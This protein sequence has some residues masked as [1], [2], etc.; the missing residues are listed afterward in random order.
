[1]ANMIANMGKNKEISMEAL[2][3][4]CNALKCEIMDFIELTD[5]LSDKSK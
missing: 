5:E 1:M 2:E 3:K 4:I